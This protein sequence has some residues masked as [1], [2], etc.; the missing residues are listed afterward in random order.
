[1][2]VYS[3][4]KQCIYVYICTSCTYI[5]M[6]RE[7]HLRSW[8]GQSFIM[9]ITCFSILNPDQCCPYRPMYAVAR[10]QRQPLRCRGGHMYVCIYVTLRHHHHQ[11]ASANMKCIFRSI[12]S[13]R[14]NI[15]TKFQ[16]YFKQKNIYLFI[17]YS[18][19]NTYCS[20]LINK[21]TC[22]FQ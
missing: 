1:M 18:F 21:L 19:N 10:S 16:R 22:L 20:I 13:V 6:T 3:K 9:L 15:R 7:L 17:I 12:H 8:N 5:G 11:L 2:Y 14:M 4:C